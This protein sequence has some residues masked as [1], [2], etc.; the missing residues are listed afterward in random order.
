[1]PLVAQLAQKQLLLIFQITADAGILAVRLATLG[2]VVILMFVQAVDLAVEIVVKVLAGIL[3]FGLTRR[4]YCR[5]C[6]QEGPDYKAIAFPT[7]VHRSMPPR[8]SSIWHP[9][10]GF[11]WF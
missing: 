8:Q 10:R 11:S 9:G 2:Q 6:E 4:E 5:R 1:L 3:K 7:L